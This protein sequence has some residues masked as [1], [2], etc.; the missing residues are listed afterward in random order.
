MT[1]E[2]GGVGFLFCVTFF[3]PER[4]DVGLLT[5]P[6]G[7]QVFGVDVHLGFV[8]GGGCGLGLGFLGPF[9]GICM[10]ISTR[11]NVESKQFYRILGDLFKVLFKVNH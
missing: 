2:P 1:V 5:R 10:K 11:Y 9:G 3:C 6:E 7:L 8:G 4:L